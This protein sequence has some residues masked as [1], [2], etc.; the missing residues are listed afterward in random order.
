MPFLQESLEVY[1]HHG[2]DIGI[3]QCLERMGEI[4]RRN[5]RHEEAVATLGEAV[6]IASRSGDRLGEAKSRLILGC[7]YWNQGEYEQGAA[8]LT[9]VRD[10]AQ[11]IGWEVGVCL[12]LSRLGS[13]RRNQGNDAAAEELYRESIA[14]ARRSGAASWI[15]AQTLHNLG[16]CVHSQGR[17]EECAKFLEESTSAYRDIAYRG[18]EMAHTISVLGDVKKELGLRD[19]AVYWYDQTVLEYAKLKDRFKMSVFLV[20][21]AMLLL[22]MERYDEAALN[23]EASMILDREMGDDGDVSWNRGKIGSIPRTAMKWESKWHPDP[24]NLDACGSC[25]TPHS[26]SPLSDAQNIQRRIPRLATAHL[27]LSI[28]PGSIVGSPSP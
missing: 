10:I 11:R 3:V 28:R 12:A 20:R 6:A 22:E 1:Q 7:T 9:G 26:S 8:T 14:A 27:R 21:K 15:L 17:P 5:L 18:N 13:L 23:F 25:S 24:G 4:H 19:D 16:L 2:H